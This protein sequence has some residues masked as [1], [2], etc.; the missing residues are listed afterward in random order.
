MLRTRQQTGRSKECGG[1]D[2]RGDDQAGLAT[3]AL[4]RGRRPLEQREDQREAAHQAQPRGRRRDHYCVGLAGGI[5]FRDSDC[6]HGAGIQDDISR[7]DQRSS[8]G[9]GSRRVRR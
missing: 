2:K 3:I 8:T 7:H 1:D 5:A 4:Q 6:L 9:Q